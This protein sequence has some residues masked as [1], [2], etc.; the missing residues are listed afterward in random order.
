[1]DWELFF[2]TL[3][4]PL[5]LLGFG[6]YWKINPPKKINHLYGYRTRRSM[7]NQQIWDHANR[8]GAKMLLWLGWV[9]LAISVLLFLLVPTY[10]I[11]I[12]TFILLIGIGMGMYWCETQLNRHYDRNGNPKP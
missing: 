10:A 8:I 3:L 11:L 5:L 7:A 1:M 6:W 2:G 4:T 9:T 12:A